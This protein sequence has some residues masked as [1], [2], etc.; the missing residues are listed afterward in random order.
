MG[1]SLIYLVIN[2]S[3]APVNVLDKL[4]TMAQKEKVG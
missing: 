2:Q 1:M 3:T 4:A